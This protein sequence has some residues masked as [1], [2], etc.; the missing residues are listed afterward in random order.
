VDPRVG[1]DMEKRKS[2][3]GPELRFLGRPARRYPGS[4][5]VLVWGAVLSAHLGLVG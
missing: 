4:L 3:T 5:P 1:L 2:L